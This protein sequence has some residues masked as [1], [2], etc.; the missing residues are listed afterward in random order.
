M[1]LR[2]DT[3]ERIQV[4]EIFVIFGIL[5]FCSEFGTSLWMNGI[6]VVVEDWVKRVLFDLLEC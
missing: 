1:K 6:P 4:S 2:C 5:R 3:S